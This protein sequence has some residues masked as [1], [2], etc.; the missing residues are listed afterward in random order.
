[1]DQTTIE[2]HQNLLPPKDRDIYALMTKSI[3]KTYENE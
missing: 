3:Q 2:T 1:M